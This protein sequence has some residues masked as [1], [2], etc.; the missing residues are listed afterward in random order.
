MYLF[1]RALRTSLDLFKML[2][3]SGRVGRASAASVLSL[4]V[5]FLLTFVAATFHEIWLAYI[6][7]PFLLISCGLFMAFVFLG[8]MGRFLYDHV[9]DEPMRARFRNNKMFKYFLEIE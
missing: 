9:M 2:W 4:I 8:G 7:A 1:R 3:R 6:A 5:F